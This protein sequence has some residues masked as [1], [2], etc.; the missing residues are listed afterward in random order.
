MQIISWF[1]NYLKAF[2]PLAG[3]RMFSEIAR[4]NQINSKAPKPVWVPSL[5][6]RV[7][8]RA[9]LADISIFQ[10]VFVK[11]EYDISEAPQFDQIRIIYHDELA[12]GRRPVIVDCGAHIGLSV[13]WFSKMFPEAQ[14]FA[15]EPN[16]ENFTLLCRNTEGLTNV[17]LMHGGIWDTPGSLVIENAGAGMSAFRLT[18]TEVMSTA[19]MIPAFTIDDILRLAGHNRAL[20]VK[21]DIEGGE[22]ALFR[23]NTDWIS[24]AGLIVIELHDWLYPWKCTSQNFFRQMS[25]FEFD[26]LTRGENTFCFSHRTQVQ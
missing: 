26:Y 5:S 18:Q 15:I 6:R 2:G 13:L 21:I 9:A 17:T 8:L 14:I 19:E 4:L 23:S 12:R 16:R 24:H 10:Q 11:K 20:L 3:L 22:A 1:P 25:T 7:W